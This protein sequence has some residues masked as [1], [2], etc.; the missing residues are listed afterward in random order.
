M[1]DKDINSLEHTRWRCQYHI[2]FAP[3]FRRMEIYKEIKVD[4]G[5]I[6]RQLCHQ[7]EIEILE[8]ELCPDQIHMLVS[9]PPKYSIVYHQ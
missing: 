6:L 7:K 3:K 2:V 4:T 8:A 1:R 5:K 9:V